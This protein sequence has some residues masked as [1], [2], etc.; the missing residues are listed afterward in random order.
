MSYLV[1]ATKPNYKLQANVNFGKEAEIDLKSGL[2]ISRDIVGFAKLQ[3][4]ISGYRNLSLKFHHA[5]KAMKFTS[6][7]K[8]NYA[9]DKE[10][11]G[12]LNFNN[13]KWR[14]ISASAEL[15]TPF[16]GVESTKV[17]FILRNKATV[18][19]SATSIEYNNGKKMN[20]NMKMTFS[21]NY[22]LQVKINTP[23]KGL[24]N[25]RAN[26]NVDISAPNFSASSSLTLS[27]NNYKAAGKLNLI[28][29]DKL[30]GS[31]EV[32][33]P[34]E[35]L[36]STKAEYQHKLDSSN[37]NGKASLSY[38]NGRKTISA[39]IKST[40]SPSFNAKVAIKTPIVGYR[41]ILGSASLE[42]SSKKY[43]A[44]SSLKIEGQ[45]LHSM[46]SGL[47]FSV[48]PMKAFTK[49]N[50]FELVLTHEGELSNFKS[51]GFLSSPLT[52]KV[53]AD[54]AFE[55]KSLS[56]LSVSASL[57]TG[58]SGMNNLRLKMDTSDK[59]GVQ[60]I[61]GLAGW[62]D[63]K[64]ISSDLTLQNSMTSLKLNLATPFAELRS[65]S[66]QVEGKSRQGGKLALE[67]NGDQLL[68]V[69]GEY[70]RKDSKA[71]LTFNKPQP[72]HFSLG[73]SRKDVDL[74]A[75]WNRDELNSNVRLMGAMNSKDISNVRLMG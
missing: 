61:S 1:D 23:F 18:I 22:N 31:F 44:S 40:I 71:S 34:F 33:T 29:Y 60:K 35:G 10:I 45:E 36:E 20:G 24:K 57:K 4:P 6:E 69:N 42:E 16:S 48:T 63:E 9:D 2:D 3:T 32:N 39:E 47:D 62:T 52:S 37:V 68:D 38:D 54:V 46:R 70:S 72:M 15:S 75:N 66:A 41:N 56:D 13:Y 55:L 30:Y 26:A 65:F 43:N 51:T 14:T 58:L 12:K 25:I 53:N 17:D 67:L 5:G 19:S 8:F 49:I 64:Q 73:G 21:P 59:S 27:R 28:S 11:E 50:N 7:G 74:Y